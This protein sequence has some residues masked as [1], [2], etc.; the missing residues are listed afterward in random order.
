IGTKFLGLY[1][2]YLNITLEKGKLYS[3]ATGE[4]KQ[5]MQPVSDTRFW[6]KSYDASIYFNLNDQGDVESITYHKSLCKKKEPIQSNDKE[7]LNAYAG[8]YHSAELNTSY[9]VKYEDEQFYIAHVSNGKVPLKR[10][11]NDGFETDAFYMPLVD[12]Q[13]DD[14]GT[15]VSLTASQYRSRNIKFN[16]MQSPN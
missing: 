15:I 14:K 7:S 2:V 8:W 5:V 6:V 13:R 11:W 12:F 4:N 1:M 10:V 16:K 9:Q 3:Q